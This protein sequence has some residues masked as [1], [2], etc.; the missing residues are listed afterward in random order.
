M[1]WKVLI[2]PF[3]RAFELLLLPVG[4]PIIPGAL[5]L[6]GYLWGLKRY[7]RPSSLD[8]ITVSLTGLAD[9][10]TAAADAT[11]TGSPAEI[12]PSAFLLSPL[13]STPTE[14]LSIRPQQFLLSLC[15]LCSISPVIEA[16]WVSACSLLEL[17][18][19]HPR[20]PTP[21]SGSVSLNY[22][23][24]SSAPSYAPPAPPPRSGPYDASALSLK[25]LRTP[26][27][28]P[29]RPGRGGG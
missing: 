28:R 10:P 19:V 4:V 15:L 6:P 22:S 12:P 29:P 14:T 2:L 18:A 5:F 17:R 7:H 11:L 23:P 3:R 21:L 16:E 1:P 25:P 27:D 8:I 24:D 26:Q 9:P 13:S 20:P